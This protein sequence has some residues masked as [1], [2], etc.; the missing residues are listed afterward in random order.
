[1]FR[2]ILCAVDL[3][4]ESTSTVTK[5]VQIAHQFNSKIVLLYVLEEFMNKD[6][7][8]MLRV[9]I[10]TVKSDFAKTA[11]MAKNEMKGIMHKLHAED[12]DVKFLLKEGQSNKIICEEAEKNQSDLIIVGN[13]SNNSLVNFLF[14]SKT[15]YIIK[16]VNIPVLLVPIK[17]V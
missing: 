6:E 1:M 5:A 11:I 13:S 10:E 7:M 8:K 3:N 4:V 15:N 2:N 16:H 12:I 17:S 9:N 14:S